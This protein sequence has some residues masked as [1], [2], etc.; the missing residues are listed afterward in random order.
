M[1]DR[2]GDSMP[3]I[4]R[5]DSHGETGGTAPPE[6]KGGTAARD[7]NDGA[8]SQ[9]SNRN[10]APNI[11]PRTSATDLTFPLIESLERSAPS[12][13]RTNAD[14]VTWRITFT[15]AVRNVDKTDFV[16]I[17][18]Q[19]WSLTLTK[20]NDAGSVYEITLN[21]DAL[22]DHNGTVALAL[23]PSRTI[24][25]LAGNDLVNR[26]LSGEF[27]VFI[28][29]TGPRI[30]YEPGNR[31]I[32]D[33][34]RNLTLTFTSAV[35][36]DSSRTPFTMMTLAGLIEI[37]KHDE[38]GDAIAFT[39][40]IDEDND[41]VTIDPIGR[42]PSRSWVRVNNTYY[43]SAGHRGEGATAIVTAEAPT[44]STG[45]GGH[46]EKPSGEAARL[47]ATPLTPPTVT[48]D[49]VPP[50]D[51][52]SFMATVT[53]SEAVTGFAESDLRV[54]NATTSA[55]TEVQAGQQ[56]H[57]RI[58]P[59]GDHGVGGR[60]TI[61]PGIEV[62]HY[63]VRL[64]ANRVTDMAGNGNTASARHT[65]SYGT[66]VTDPR[67]LSIVRQTPSISSAQADSITW[68]V[69]FSE[70][71]Q[72]FRT[73]SVNLLADQS[74][75][76]IRLSADRVSAVGHSESVYDV[77][78][79]GLADYTGRVRLN[80]QVRSDGATYSAYIQ[81]K[82]ARSLRCCETMGTDERTFDLD[83]APAATERRRGSYGDVSTPPSS[84]PE[85]DT[86]LGQR[87]P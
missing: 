78:F 66:D 64:P 48:I 9:R 72:H 26:S 25:D 73:S 10:A 16:I 40:S 36:S 42:L 30:T 46:G 61:P 60:D 63:G 22:A 65:G 69:T 82:S 1:R 85:L 20:V 13:Y 19:P 33:A 32:D 35:Y 39:A 49:G 71:V 12:A 34:L 52:G 6:D 4:A 54:T 62:N 11:E 2:A 75:R 57:V 3:S 70:D 18:I 68:R 5:T 45:S 67:L 27:E 53:F 76:V 38:N 58:T 80:F 77:T 83:R 37:R 50:T 29:N 79:G 59:T 7:D 44:V 43:D 56:W 87:G 21:S 86:A 51:S 17:G 81:D 8:A 28:D 15:E 74:D 23:S 24:E 55:F 84:E 31:S 41:T 47:D 14:S